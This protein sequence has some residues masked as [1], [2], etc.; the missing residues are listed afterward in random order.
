[1]IRYAIVVIMVNISIWLSACGTVQT[2]SSCI[3][4][5]DIDGI[6][7]KSCEKP[8]LTSVRNVT[9]PYSVKISNSKI[10]TLKFEGE[11]E[12]IKNALLETINN[13]ENA[14]GSRFSAKEL[15][16]KKYFIPDMKCSHCAKRIKKALQNAKNTV[17]ELLVFEK[18]INQ[19]ATERGIYILVKNDK[20]L[21]QSEIDKNIIEVISKAG[22]KAF[23]TKKAKIH[24]E[25]TKQHKEQCENDDICKGSTVFGCRCKEL[26]PGCTCLHCSGKAKTCPCGL[27]EKNSKNTHHHE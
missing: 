8:L 18:D 17:G 9:K 13:T 3:A 24:N 15:P 25:G 10:L 11:C 7:C 27:D 14:M 4:A 12:K 5:F 19:D 21:D 26:M 6:H 22:F 23:T 20:N 16:L 1:M 2:V